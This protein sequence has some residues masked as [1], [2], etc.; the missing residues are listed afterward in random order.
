MMKMA[1]WLNGAMAEWK[2]DNMGNVME[3]GNGL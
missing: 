3:C 2:C 1:E